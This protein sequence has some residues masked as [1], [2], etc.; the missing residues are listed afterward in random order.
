MDPTDP[1]HWFQGRLWIRSQYRHRHSGFPNKWIRK[2]LSDLVPRAC[3][4][5]CD[6]ELVVASNLATGSFL[7]TSE[8][9]PGGNLA[10]LD[11]VHH[12]DGGDVVLPPCQVVPPVSLHNHFYD[13]QTKNGMSDPLWSGSRDLTAVPPGSWSWLHYSTRTRTAGQDEDKSNPFF[14]TEEKGDVVLATNLNGN[15]L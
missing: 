15:R 3:N 9:V 14:V 6:S 2:K 10:E 11:Q 4:I 7:L 1:E 12:I 8:P 13:L 5:P